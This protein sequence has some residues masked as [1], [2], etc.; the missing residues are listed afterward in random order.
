MASK[1]KN[2]TKGS[3]VP[4]IFFFWAFIKGGVINNEK[5]IHKGQICPWGP[6]SRAV[7]NVPAL[8]QFIRLA[9]TLTRSVK[10]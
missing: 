1:D 4:S 6:N 7:L 3:T 9:S 2:D 5:K 10:V 8:D